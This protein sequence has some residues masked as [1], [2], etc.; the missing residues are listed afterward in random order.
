MSSSF[1]CNPHNLS[2]TGLIVQT[3]GLA[4]L[5]SKSLKDSN[6]GGARYYEEQF[7][8]LV[9]KVWEAEEQ[10]EKIRGEQKTSP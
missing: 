9:S 5:M 4:M 8:Q 2:T 1:P 3:F 10:C 6:Q 7:E